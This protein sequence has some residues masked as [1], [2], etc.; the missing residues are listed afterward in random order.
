[1]TICNKCNVNQ[2]PAYRVKYCDVCAEQNKA[3]HEA[4]QKQVPAV[5]KPVNPEVLKLT[6][7]PQDVKFTDHFGKHVGEV[8]QYTKT[9]A[10]NSY[11]VGK[12]GDRF[13]LYFETVEELQGKIAELKRAGFMQDEF[14]SEGSS[15]DRN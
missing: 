6:K 9:L 1:M 2:V 8:M 7:Y 12:V 4:N 10:A 11:E 14:K 15:T 13:K 5:P 3:E